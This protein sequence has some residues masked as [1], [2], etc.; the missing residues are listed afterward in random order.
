VKPLVVVNP[1][2]ADAEAVDTLGEL[3]VATV[4]EAQGRSG[5]LGT[6]LR[7]LWPG[8]RM[9]G[10]AVTVLCWS[11][12]NLMVHVAVEQARPGDVLVI[13]TSSPSTDGLV[14]ELLATVMRVRGVRGL[15]VDAG[16]RDV[17]ELRRL[18]F[19]V[20]SRAI[21]AQGTVKA[22]AGSVNVPISVGGTVVRPGDAIVADDDGVV[23]V[24]REQAAAVVAA[25]RARVEREDAARA[26]FA[27][28]ELGLDRYGLRPLLE[29][30]GVSYVEWEER[31]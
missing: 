2:R 23:C 26:A 15:V 5:L 14:G 13:T 3:G 19:P 6:E 9:A 20:W 29:K 30:L 11:G 10:T 28:G 4:H 17:A 31:P 22:S 8:A 12:D 18:E 27:A 25:G 1:P 16:V 24:P 21:S 7:P